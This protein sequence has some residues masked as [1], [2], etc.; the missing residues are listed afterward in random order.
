[1]FVARIGSFVC[2]PV[3]LL[4]AVASDRAEADTPSR[5]PESSSGGPW[6]A[7]A[8][9]VDAKQKRS[10]EFNY[11]EENVPAYQLPDPLF[12][13]K[14]SAS[15][16]LESWGAIRTAQLKLFRTHVYGERPSGPFSVRFETESPQS[17]RQG[18]IAAIA[19]RC[20]IHRPGREDGFA[21]PF[22]IY[23]PAADSGSRPVCIHINNRE[24]Y[25]IDRAKEAAD[26][27]SP[28]E[29]LC[30]RGYALLTFHTSDVDP[31]RAD[32]YADGV[33]A[34]FS[35][36]PEAEPNE[37]RSLSAW[38]WAASRLLDHVSQS[39]DLDE[40]R[41]AV[42][43]HSRGGKA[44]LWAAAED[45]R[46][47]VAYSNQSGCGGAALSRRR[48]GET[49][50]RITTAFPHWFV[51]RFAGYAGRESQLPVDQHQLIGLIAP[52]PV[53]VVSADEDL[54][55]DPRGEYLSIVNAAP[56]YE[57]L[58]KSSITD[59]AMPPLDQPRVVGSTGYHIR[60]GRHD[61]TEK[62]WTWFLDFADRSLEK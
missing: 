11:V 41:V 37:W 21:F 43:G 15:E 60:R 56:V 9:L 36:R 42:V 35:D 12:A 28:I 17:I 7:D 50:D 34:F 57:R 31:D 24:F 20:I 8:D 14:P 3:L 1:M 5:R 26:D 48:Y 6:R 19:G 46:F 16:G 10:D 44:A 30:G 53:Y 59:P 62:D 33:R 39:A 52:R 40:T 23:R 55:A 32:G 4:L 18:T 22:V 49:V 27:F 51:P 2:I 47:A 25:S 29:I 61:L 13:T 54:W 45:T 58:G 38:G